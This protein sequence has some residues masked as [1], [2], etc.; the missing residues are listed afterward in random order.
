MLLQVEKIL[1][2]QKKIKFNMNRPNCTT[3]RARDVEGWA[4]GKPVED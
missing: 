2:Q 3:H 4:Q 1:K